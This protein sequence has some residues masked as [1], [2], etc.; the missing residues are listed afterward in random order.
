MTALKPTPIWDGRGRGGMADIAVIG[1]AKTY[2]GGAEKSLRSETQRR[3]PP[4][5]QIFADKN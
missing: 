5:E 2:H 1:K 4:A 3:W